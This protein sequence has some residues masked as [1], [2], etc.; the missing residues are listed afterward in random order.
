MA[1]L[2]WVYLVLAARRLAEG[3]ATALADGL[4]LV[5]WPPLAFLLPPLGALLGFA[6]GATHPGYV[7]TVTE[8]LPLL[9][10]LVV[11]GT[12][13]AH[14]GLAFLAGY[15]LGDVLLFNLER[16]AL[17]PGAV[18]K[19]LAAGDPPAAAV[20]LAVDLG[21]YW[22]PLVIQ[23]GLMALPLTTFPVLAKTL[24]RSLSGLA[25]LGPW[26]GSAA[27][28]AVHAALTFALVYFWTQSIPLLIRPLFFWRGESPAVAAVAPAQTHGVVIAAVAVVASVVRMGLQ[29]LTTFVPRFRAPLDPA[30]ERLSAG[31]P[32]TPLAERTPRPLAVLGRALATTVLLAGLYASWADWAALFGLVVLLE[33]VRVGLV[34]LPL[35]RWAEVVQ[36]LPLVV[37]VAG[38]FGAIAL[39]ASAL[40]PLIDDAET[41]RP[42]ILLTGMA[43]VVS[44]LFNPVSPL[45]PRAQPQPE[46]AR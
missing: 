8:S 45:A 34:P 9:L 33:T 20:A 15:V 42:L 43:M 19:V 23:Y 25:L 24:L 18:G 46:A 31:P 13:S 40:T 28:A 7:T 12:L 27:A 10:L 38:A 5:V 36:R 41:F 21:S 16:L 32:L 30:L 22:L 26:V 11:L 3:L 37:R 35:G 44:F 6:I 39:L 14:L 17:L 2:W 4:Y 1:W 29:A